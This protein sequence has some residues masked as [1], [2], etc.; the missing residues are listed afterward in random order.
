ML[1]SSCYSHTHSTYIIFSISRKTQGCQTNNN[2]KLEM[3]KKIHR[4]QT[5]LDTFHFFFVSLFLVL[6]VCVCTFSL[7][8]SFSFMPLSSGLL[9][10]CYLIVFNLD[11]CFQFFFP[12][13]CFYFVSPFIYLF[14]C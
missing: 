10:L 2:N 1:F 4:L 8:F 9:F 5:I 11:L 7:F 13:F 12:S 6:C 3:K 14:S